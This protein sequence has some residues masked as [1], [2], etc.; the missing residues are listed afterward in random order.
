MRQIRLVL[1]S[2]LDV[3]VYANPEFNSEY[4]RVIREEIDL[5]IMDANELGLQAHHKIQF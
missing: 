4:M 3:S 2:G 5:K 1:E